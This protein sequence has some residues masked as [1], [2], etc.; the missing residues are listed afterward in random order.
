MG[1]TAC[2]ESS[3]AIDENLRNSTFYPSF[4]PWSPSPALL[5]RALWFIFVGEAYVRKSNY[6][7][8]R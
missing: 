8:V 7:H 5:G 4:S 3:E 6:D 2:A 1:S